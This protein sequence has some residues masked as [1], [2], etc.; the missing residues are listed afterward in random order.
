VAL[1]CVVDSLLIVYRSV[2]KREL[3]AMSVTETADCL[4]ITHANVKTRLQRPLALLRTRLDASAPLLRPA[5]RLSTRRLFLSTRMLASSNHR[6][7]K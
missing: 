1:R 7:I 5:H 3:E 2:V 4:G 6:D